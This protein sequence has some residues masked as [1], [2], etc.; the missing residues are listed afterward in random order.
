MSY[1]HMANNPEITVS[2]LAELL[3]AEQEILRRLSLDALTSQ[4]F[5]LDPVQ[6]LANVGI[7]LS[8]IAIR[9]WEDVTPALRQR[10]GAQGSLRY[11]RIKEEGG[12]AGLKVTVQGL[13]APSGINATEADAEVVQ[14]LT[15][16]A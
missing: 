9:E 16:Q 8:S 14:E 13:V 15:G 12:L 5:L 6:A 4:M 3:A 10:D 1:P 7:I 11:K 2:S